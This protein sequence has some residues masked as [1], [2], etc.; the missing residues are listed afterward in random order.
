MEPVQWSEV[1]AERF[2]EGIERRV[3]WGRA[4][5]LARF[6]IAAGTHVA[7]HS[8]S[9]EQFTH[10]V[11]GAMRLRVGE[12]TIEFRP[13]DVF[14]IPAGAPHEAWFDAESVV[15]DFFAPPRQDWRR[16][17]SAYLGPAAGR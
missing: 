17:E 1:S 12:R 13:G 10:L 6:H 8:H 2:G 9:S 11:A 15:L 7:E 5:T 14:V 16:G 4:G 3:V